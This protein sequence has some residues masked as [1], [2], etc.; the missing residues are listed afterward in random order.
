VAACAGLCLILCGGTAPGFDGDLSV[1]APAGIVIGIERQRTRQFL[2]IPYAAPPVGSLRW[3]PPRPVK[4]KSPYR[5]DTLP[6]PCPQNSAN[7]FAQ[8]SVSEDCLYLNVFTPKT[9]SDTT[10]RVPVMVW[11]HGGGFFSGSSADYDGSKLARDGHVVVVTVNYRIGALGFFSHPAI[12][13]ESHPA[14]NYGLMDQQFALR[15]IKKNIAAFG[16]DASVIT[17]WGQSSGGTSVLANLISPTAKGLFGRA[18]NQSGTHLSPTPASTALD[19]AMSFASSAGC[20]NQSRDCLR[21]LPVETVLAHQQDL[22]ATMAANF[23]V[24][25]GTIITRSPLDAFRSGAFNRVPIVNGLNADEQ[26]YFLAESTTKIPL[27]EKG[28]ENWAISIG[29]ADAAAIMS[30]Y[31]ID[32]FG[33]ASLAEIA[34]AQDSKTCTALMLDR[35]WSRYVPVLAYEFADRTAP[36]YYPERSYPMRAFHTAELQYL[37]PRFHGARGESHPLN[38]EQ[39]RLASLMVDYWTSFA[40]A[41]MPASVYAGPWAAFDPAVNNV[42][43]FQ[44]GTASI[45]LDM[46]PDSGSGSSRERCEFWDAI[47]AWH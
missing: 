32:K 42:L 12:N 4:W 7:V 41:G 39:D 23:P 16:G 45:R 44:S 37:F 8:P 10:L 38:A 46:R 30:R 25:D 15:W 13:A 27:T 18:I 21:S 29:G 22:I 36:S 20:A 19:Q 5:A 33:S 34:A 28:Y 6:N 40:K 1:N 3:R 11:I 35:V 14:I 43:V 17:L 31:P 9:I 26:A 24:V 47:N 2:G